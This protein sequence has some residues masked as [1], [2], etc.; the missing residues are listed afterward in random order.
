MNTDP[1]LILPFLI[2]PLFGGYSAFPRVLPFFL[3]PSFLMNEH[4]HIDKKF[5]MKL[6][7]QHLSRPALQAVQRDI[8][9]VSA[10]SSFSP[11]SNIQRQPFSRRVIASEKK[12]NSSSPSSSSSAAAAAK[13]VFQSRKKINCN[14][15]SM[16]QK[17]E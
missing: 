13:F 1:L 12:K 14:E 6:D 9:Q 11:T 3:S 16:T 2:L 10:S 8:Y 7:K 4:T 5:K 15:I 17:K